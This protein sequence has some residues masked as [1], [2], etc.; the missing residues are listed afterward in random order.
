MLT[1]S[2]WLPSI[3]VRVHYSKVLLF[4]CTHGSREKVAWFVLAL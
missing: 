1:C 3:F 4:G 2:R